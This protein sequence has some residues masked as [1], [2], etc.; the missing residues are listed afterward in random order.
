MRRAVDG[1]PSYLATSEAMAHFGLG[2]ATRADVV[3]VW[4]PNGDVTT[5]HDVPAGEV[6]TVPAVYV[7]DIN[8]DGAVG[9]KVNTE[10]GAFVVP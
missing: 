3:E 8:R 2:G 1:G 5:L 4:W 6:L 10:V 9:A 7:G